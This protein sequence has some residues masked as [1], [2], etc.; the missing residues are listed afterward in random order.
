MNSKWLVRS[1]A[2]AVAL[3]SFPGAGFAQSRS[4]DNAVT[5]AEDAFG[6]SVG[7]ESLGIYSSGSV[8]GFS[9]TAA[10]NLRI[11]GLYFDQIASLQRMLVDSVSI[12]V[13]L[14]AQGYPFTAPSGIVD[15]KLREP[16]DKAGASVVTNLDTYGSQGVEID[17]SVPVTPTLA[18]AYGFNGARLRFYDGTR[19]KF[20]HSES[21][22]TRW[23][24]SPTLEIMPFWGVS[25]DY[26]DQASIFFVPAGSFLPMVPRPGHYAGPSWAGIRLATMNVGVLA[27][28]RLGQN[29]LLRLGAF[30]S[31][32]DFKRNFTP[33]LDQEQPDGRGE[34][35]IFVDPRS[36]SSS[37]SG[38][39]RLTHSIQDGPRLH[40]VHLSLRQRVTTDQFGGADFI[41]L[42][43]G[44]F[45]LKVQA[46]PPAQFLFEPQSHDRET[47]TIAG[48]AYDGRW[49]SVGEFSF[50][51]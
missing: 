6:F 43:P 8:R 37:D 14:S 18:L 49:K 29:W 27:S 42:G 36:I 40:L 3:A 51:I 32:S 28:A 23:K 35:T 34:R 24:P 1:W 30:R 33:I 41:D 21:L 47:Q 7:R 25:N 50:G 17:G 4:G 39:L 5:E 22:L 16:S 26:S 31:V 48:I 44:R 2:G 19:D 20:F 45:D 11:D 10:G 46:P 38:E 12:K 15:E 13:G 9:P